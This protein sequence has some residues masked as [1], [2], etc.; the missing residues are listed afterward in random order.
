[1]KEE[2]AMEIRIGRVTHFYNQISV[3]VL[4]LEDELKIGDTVVFL[5]HTTDFTQEVTSMEIEHHKILSGG[6]GLEVALKV[7]E[8]VRKG[9]EVLKVVASETVN[10]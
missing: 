4:E 6:P 1:L 7:D 8:P 10:A 5:G 3:A 2:R 9:D